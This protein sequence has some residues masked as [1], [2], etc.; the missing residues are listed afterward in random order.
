M[1]SARGRS[2]PLSSLLTTAYT[3]G[4]RTRSSVGQSIG[5]LIRRSQVRILP[6]ALTMRIQFCGADRTVTGSSH[7]IEVN[8]LRLLLDLGMYQGPREEA[9][10]IN[11]LLPENFQSINAIILSH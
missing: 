6:G 10:R 7:L 4:G 2:V 8:G 1:V 5:F 3:Y 11:H 9:K